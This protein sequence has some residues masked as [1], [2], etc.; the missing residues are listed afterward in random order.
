[1]QNAFLTGKKNNFQSLK[2]FKNNEFSTKKEENE[3]FDWL[4]KF[5]NNQKIF[6]DELKNLIFF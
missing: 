1:M 3:V 2:N 5:V 6:F 4:K